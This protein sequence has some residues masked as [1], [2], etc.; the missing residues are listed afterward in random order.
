[1]DP[2]AEKVLDAIIAR[3]ERIGMGSGVTVHLIERAEAVGPGR[4]L[5]GCMIVEAADGSLHRMTGAELVAFAERNPW[6]KRWRLEE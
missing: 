5:E 1:M 4:G 6:V 2:K 3:N